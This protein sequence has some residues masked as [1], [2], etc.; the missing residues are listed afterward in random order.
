M[1]ILPR[2]ITPIIALLML[3]AMPLQAKQASGPAPDFTLK[4]LDGS[5][6]KLSEQAGN[7]VMINFWA[8]W[9]APC[10]VE[11]PKLN[12]LYNKYKDLGFVLLGVNVEQQEQPMRNF[13]RKRPVDF[14]ILMDKS[15]EVSQR[16]HVVAMPTTV[17]LD[18]SG[19]IRYIHQG[20]REGDEKK[21]RQVIK[22]LLRE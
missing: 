14:P 17:L 7:V 15:N 18:R 9:C 13:L 1:N 2:W 11:M 20:Y 19:N 12:D 3:A 10:R 6:L 5:N 16:Y 4:S 21:Y 22:M 8:S